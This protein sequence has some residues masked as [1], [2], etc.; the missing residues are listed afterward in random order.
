M[1]ATMT[2][3][4]MLYE[5]TLEDEH[6]SHVPEEAWSMEHMQSTWDRLLQFDIFKRRARRPKS[7][8]GSAGHA[9]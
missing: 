7:A 8:D 4:Q 1:A 5:Y 2:L 9:K 6:G 3:F